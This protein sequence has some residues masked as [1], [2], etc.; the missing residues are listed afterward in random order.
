MSTALG[1]SR[2]FSSPYSTATSSA[3]AL[4][5]GKFDVSID[6]RGYM[7]D[8]KMLAAGDLAL[9]SSIRATRAQSDGSTEPGEQ[10]LNVDDLWRR[11]Q[12]S[13]HHGAGQDYLDRE[14]SLRTRFRQSLGI[15]VWTRGQISLLNDT[16]STLAATGTNLT[17]MPAG[18]R[19]YA[20]DGATLKY[21]TDLTNWSTTTGTSGVSISGIASDGYYI[22]VT[23]GANIYRTNTGT[24]SA[25]S[26]STEDADLIGYVKGRLMIAKGPTLKYC[27]D[28]A[29]PTFSSAL[30]THANANWAWVGFAEGP[31][32]IYTAGYVG[33]KSLI[34]RIAITAEGTALAAPT[35][36]G[37][38]PDGEIIYS[39]GS[40]LGFI[41]LGTS[42]GARF[43]NLD[44]SGNLRIGSVLPTSYPVRCFEG[45]G[46]FIWYGMTNY[47]GTNGGLG[48]MSLRY[49]S[50]IDALKPAYATDLMVTSTANITS[51]AT[52]SNVRVFAVSGV[53]YYKE[54]TANL[55][56]SG[57]IDSG[58]LNYNITEKKIPAFIDVTFASGFAGE[59]STYFAVNGSSTFTL[60]GI[61]TTASSDQTGATYESSEISADQVEI[62]QV[63]ER[64]D[65]TT[66]GPTILRH[67]IRALPIPQL[68]RKI[69]LPLL[70]HDKV[71]T[72]A[73]TWVYYVVADELAAIEHWRTSKQIMATQIGDEN[74]AGAVDDFDFLA[75]QET[76]KGSFWQ[77]TCLVYV[78]TV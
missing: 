29:T 76:A 2:T 37:E 40:Y 44:S 75:K 24:T 42:A 27:S 57:T 52:F 61:Q 51:V 68:R 23:D 71:Q 32:H 56:A 11:T 41:L 78:K 53:G 15:N 18:S 9:I 17:L 59:V 55:V 60:A 28:M 67:T 77:G 58:R 74:Y 46:D 33:D 16:T 43:C 35:V 31:G 65:P 1:F 66:S 49:F 6:G 20:T 70:L 14:D 30:F 19:L 21:T 26:W 12:Q 62:R 3:S 39:I 63:L 7:L 22:W 47:D 45:Q 69:T 4:V 64:G 38:L 73:G 36:C 8:R 10:S 54:D 48:R 13:W 72:N 5:P 34:Y 50:D 25:S